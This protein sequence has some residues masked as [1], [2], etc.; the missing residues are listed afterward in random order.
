MKMISPLLAS[1]MLRASFPVAF[2]TNQPSWKMDGDKIALNNGN[3]VYLDSDGKEMT[4]DFGTIGRLNNEAKTHRTAKETAEAALKAFEGLDAAA[5][6]SAL[7][8][9]S[10][11]DQKKLIDA[12]EV[13]KVRAA[14]SGEFTK[15]IDA[16]KLSDDAKQK[17]INAMT[18]DAAFGASEYLRDNIAMPADFIRS[19]FGQFFGVEND[20]IVA[21]DGTGNQLFSTKRA[22]EPANFDEA[23]EILVSRHPQ[24][25]SILKMNTGN[26]TGGQQQQGGR[27]ARTMRRSD[28]SQ[29][30]PAQQAEAAGRA[31]KGELNIVD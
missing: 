19:Y 5:A 29:L 17:K 20:A 25:D 16:L 23:M 12:G 27:N 2:N 15:Q 4:I 26:G 28:F 30:S 3:P 14:I 22:G 1:L 21:K 8:T 13:D 9:L 7:E 31:A 18:L 11:I 24:K 10:K 6:R